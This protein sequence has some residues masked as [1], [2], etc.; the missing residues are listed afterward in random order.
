MLN[1]LR[2]H[3]VSLRHAANGF[4]HLVK[5]HANFRLHIL[6]TFGVVILGLFL[7]L[8]PVEWLILVFTINMVIVA[9]MVNTAIE[10]MVNLI[11]LE[12]REDAK[13]AKDVSAAMVLGSAFLA[14]VIGLI[15]FWPKIISLF[16]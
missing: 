2:T 8:S 12:H 16:F 6:V 11:T 7:G 15:I 9:E 13:I 14:G 3:Q 1:R 4:L 10:S 5:E